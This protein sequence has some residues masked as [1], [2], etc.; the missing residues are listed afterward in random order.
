MD[1]VRGLGVLPGTRA[2]MSSLADPTV[3]SGL[4][5]LSPLPCSGYY[6]AQAKAA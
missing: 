4:T 3:R 5:F 2:A 1:G 6:R